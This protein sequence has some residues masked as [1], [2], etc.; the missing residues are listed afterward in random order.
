MATR[1]S[2]A[3]LLTGLSSLGFLGTALLHGTGYPSIARLAEDVPGPMGRIMPGLWL[4]FS[5]D[6]TVLGLILVVV[7]GRPGPAARPVLAVA[8]LCPL[9]AAGLQLWLIG[10]VPPTALLLAVGTLTLIGAMAWPPSSSAS[11]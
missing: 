8:A 3:R 10:F 5:I 4:I 9:A 1:A 6:L 7:A 2:R 11:P